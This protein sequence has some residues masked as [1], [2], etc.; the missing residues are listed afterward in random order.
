LV[1]ALLAATLQLVKET[2]RNTAQELSSRFITQ[3]PILC[4]L[5]ERRN[6]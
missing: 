1:Q 5:E 3:V 4:Q 6:G 2:V